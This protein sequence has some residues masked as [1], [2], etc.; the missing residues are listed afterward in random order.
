MAWPA[1]VR[2]PVADRRAC[3]AIL[4]GRTCP[5]YGYQADQSDW[6]GFK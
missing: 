5:R 1:V 4:V 6:N 3:A 2:C